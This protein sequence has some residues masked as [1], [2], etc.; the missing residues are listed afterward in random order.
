MSTQ[1]LLTSSAFAEGQSIP[2]LHT[3]EG[4]DISP[5][6]AWTAPPENTRSLALFCD[7]PDAVGGTWDHWVV[8]NL[9]ASTRELPQNVAPEPVLALGERQGRNSWGRVGYGGPCPPSGTHRYFFRLC[10]LDII[11]DLPPGAGKAQVEAAL[12]GHVL[13]Q[14][15]LMGTYRKRG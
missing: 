6:L 14:A 8:F 2:S 7:D 15:Q 10:A 9:P 13:A 4:C 3:C 1:F 12:R 5:P 11:L